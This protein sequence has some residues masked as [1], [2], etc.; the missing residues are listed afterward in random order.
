MKI[1]VFIRYTM[2]HVEYDMRRCLFII[3][4]LLLIYSLP[5]A[6]HAARVVKLRNISTVYYV[7]DESIRHAYPNQKTFESWHFP[8]FPI[9]NVQFS[10]VE[11][12]DASELAGMRLGENVM[13]R[14]GS[15]V[16]IQTMP[17]VYAVEQGGILRPL[18]GEQTAIDLYGKA[19]AKRVVDV[20]EVFFFNYKVGAPVRGRADLPDG[21]LVT[22]EQ[23]DG[24]V[25]YKD[26]GVLTAFHDDA[27]VRENNLERGK[28]VTIPPLFPI[29]SR[30][31]VGRE[32]SITD[33]QWGIPLNSADCAA[34]SLKTAVLYLS[35][36]NSG[37]VEKINTW[38]TSTASAWE[39]R[40]DVLSLM[41]MS[42]VEEM[43]FADRFLVDGEMEV[44]EVART[45]F[46]THADDIDF[47]VLWNAILP[48]GSTEIADFW[49]VTNLVDGLGKPLFER[50]ELYGSRG[51]LK[52]V[53]S[54]GRPGDYPLNDTAGMARAV[55]TG[56][57][58]FLHQWS[59]ESDFR[60]LTGADR[61]ELQTS[62]SYH[63]S[64]FVDFI[65][66]LGG[67][68]W[69]DNGDGTFT[70]MRSLISAYQ[71]ANLHFPDFDLYLMGLVPRHSVAPIRYLKP[72]K[73]S[74]VLSAIMQGNFQTVSI[75]EVVYGN[76]VRRCTAP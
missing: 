47:L 57:H 8:Q 18:V 39:R 29:R 42:P 32:L 76:G 12:I 21:T 16:K 53:I 15:L 72:A 63:W 5:L 74:D 28:A 19:W 75:D 4:L 20:P 41:A 52:A 51:K 66:P 25:Y 23:S 11:T 62:D 49:P 10:N 55:E 70:S 56:L 17:Q 69:Q 50:G 27:V 73:S 26:N 6:A 22:L 2:T 34:A 38:R 48:A 58:E 30:A 14:L 68:G 46:D 37:E 36:G 67:W 7:D 35:K 13:M 54:M 43:P 60:D 59:G 65:S 64:P 3:S 9:S 33:P 45:Y 24:K 71:L 44:Q 31:I 40:T 1:S 61:V